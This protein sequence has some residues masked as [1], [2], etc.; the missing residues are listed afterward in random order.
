[1]S[2]ATARCFALKL[3]IPPMDVFQTLMDDRMIAKGLILQFV[4]AFFQDFLSTD[5]LDELVP[6]LRKAKIDHRLQDFFPPQ[7][8]TLG[9]FEEHFKACP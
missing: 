5:S 4:T 3:G 1:M 9:D 8:R 7:K 6:L 2:A